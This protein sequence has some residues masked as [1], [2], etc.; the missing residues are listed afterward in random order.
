MDILELLRLNL[1]SPMVLAFLLGLIAV[2]VKSDLSFPKEFSSVVG[3]YLLF[4]IG[5]KGGA[6]LS[7]IP[8]AALVMPILAT[9][10][11]GAGKAALAFFILSKKFDR[12]N[13]A[14]IAAHYGS[15]SAVTFTAAL[16][17]ASTRYQNLEGY[18]PALL[19]ILEVPGIALALALAQKGDTH[20]WRE[21][22]TGRSLLMVLG[23]LAIGLL[24]GASGLEQVKPFF[25]DPF[26]GILTL[27]LLEMGL[28]AG[29]R[30]RDLHGVGVFLLGFAVL[31]PIINALV[32]MLLAKAIGLS[33]GGGFVFAVMAA[34][35]SYIA[36]PAAVR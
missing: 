8:V 17:F 16:T 4:S 34:S 2:W 29:Q 36:A 15:V 22:F 6:A 31:V 30:L 23:G 10:A 26:M 24:G 19:A 9:L 7:S 13:A 3:I 14:A 28:V 21:L 25:I 1:F 33:E 11:L 5:L 32:A 27:F 35:A 12:D 18:L 20:L